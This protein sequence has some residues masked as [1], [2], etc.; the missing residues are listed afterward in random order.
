MEFVVSKFEVE[1]PHLQE[2]LRSD[3]MLVDHFHDLGCIT[4]N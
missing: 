4:Q 3:I 2:I 1:A